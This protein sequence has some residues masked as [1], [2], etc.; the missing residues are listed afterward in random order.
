MKGTL[1]HDFFDTQKL[2]NVD[3]NAVLFAPPDDSYHS[4]NPWYG[5]HGLACQ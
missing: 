5:K 1:C 2:V 3:T 4:P